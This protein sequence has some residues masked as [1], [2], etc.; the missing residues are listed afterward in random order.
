MDIALQVDFAFEILAAAKG[1][2]AAEIYKSVDTHMTDS[3]EHNKGFA[4]LLAEL[5]NLDTTAG[6]LFGG[7][8]TTLGFS[9]AIKKMISIVEGEMKLEKIMSH[10]M[11]DLDFN[12]KNGSFAGQALN[13]MLKL[14]APEFIQK[15]W[16]YYKLYDKFLKDEAIR[17]FS[18]H[19][20]TTDLA[21]YLEQLLF[22]C[23]ILI[24]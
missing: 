12:S 22:F 7:A 3:T 23:T 2:T 14:V 21:V 1:T 16:N 4:A 10:F 6:Q 13:M 19:T 8:H 18:L 20:K 9:R 24:G 15:P 17:M 5:Y 11:A